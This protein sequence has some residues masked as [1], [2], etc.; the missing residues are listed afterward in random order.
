MSYFKKFT[1]SDIGLFLKNIINQLQRPIWMNA[2]TGAVRS[3]DTVTTV[4]TA[5]SVTN[6]GTIGS[7]VQTIPLLDLPMRAAW[8]ASVRARINTVRPVSYTFVDATSGNVI[9]NLPTAVG[10][11]NDTYVIKKIDS[12]VNAVTVTPFGAETIDGA[13]T[14]VMTRQYMSYTIVSDGMNWMVV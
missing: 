9:V 4:T 8:A 13:A 12:S 5:A 11:I 14:L 6:V 2:S 1:L 3:V 10:C 7:I